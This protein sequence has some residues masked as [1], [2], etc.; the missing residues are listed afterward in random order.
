MIFRRQNQ[1]GCKILFSKDASWGLELI[2]ISFDNIKFYQR[3]AIKFFTR[4]SSCLWQ[5]EMYVK[6]DN[7]TDDDMSDFRL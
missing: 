7:A 4:I 1:V 5:C 6:A 3:V 2:F